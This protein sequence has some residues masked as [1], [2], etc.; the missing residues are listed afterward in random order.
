M[1]TRSEG[2]GWASAAAGT[3]R[4]AA[5]KAGRQSVLTLR[6]CFTRPPPGFPCSRSDARFAPGRNDGGGLRLVPRPS[7]LPVSRACPLLASIR[8]EALIAPS[9]PADIGIARRIVGAIAARA[10]LLVPAAVVNCNGRSDGRG[11][12][13]P[14]IGIPVAVVVIVVAVPTIG[15]TRVAAGVVTI[16]VAISVAVVV[17][18]A[19][20]V[21]GKL[22]RAVISVAVSIG[23]AAVDIP[24]ISVSASSI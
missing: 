21:G 9:A 1:T 2:A 3:N 11:A 15:V 4:A 16:V 13:P 22:R 24:V 12:Q 19:I 7:S 20:P 6:N 18:V 14:R 5:T 10:P 17:A 23:A 8:P